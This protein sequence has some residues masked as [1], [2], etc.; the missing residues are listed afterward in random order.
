M[1]FILLNWI[2]K[3]RFEAGFLLV[4]FNSLFFY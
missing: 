3:T 1:S 2:L 4:E